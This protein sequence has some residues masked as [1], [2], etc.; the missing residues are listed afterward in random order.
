MPLTNPA[1]FNI[2]GRIGRIAPLRLGV[3]GGSAD[4]FRQWNADGAWRFTYRGSSIGLDLDEEEETWDS[5]NFTP[6][7]VFMTLDDAVA[8]F[9][10]DGDWVHWHVS[11]VHPDYK[12]HVWLLR[13][14]TIK[15]FDERQAANARRRDDRWAR[16]CGRRLQN[17]PERRSKET[18]RIVVR[19][20][21][22]LE[23][24]LVSAVAILEHLRN[25][26]M[27]S[28]E[29]KTFEARM[30]SLLETRRAEQ[31]ERSRKLRAKRSVDTSGSKET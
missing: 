7:G 25:E 2:F 9:S 24:V 28:E 10:S 14:R 23:A 11:K 22:T 8:G 3:E 21:G 13:E 31:P 19:P 4:F 18:N 1:I 26:P 20:S 15:S 29:I 16:I 12:E 17:R 30:V 5:A 27:S 6:P